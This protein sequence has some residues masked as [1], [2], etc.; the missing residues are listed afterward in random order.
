[1][2]SSDDTGSVPISRPEIL[3][4]DSDFSSSTGTGPLASP[5]QNEELLIG[6]KPLSISNLSSWESSSSTN[7][8]PTTSDSCC[9]LPIARAKKTEFYHNRDEIND[10][11]CRYT[12]QIPTTRESKHGE[13]TS[14]TSH[15]KLPPNV[16]NFPNVHCATA[17]TTLFSE[18]MDMKYAEMTHRQLTL[19]LNQLQ[20]HCSVSKLDPAST[21]AMNKVLNDSHLRRPQAA[22]AKTSRCVKFDYSN[23]HSSKADCSSPC[24]SKLA[25]ILKIKDEMLQEK[26]TTIV[27]LRL[28]ISSLQ[29]QAQETEAVLHQV[30]CFC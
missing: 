28:Q 9:T 30:N 14:M 3:S 24:Y 16:N 25:Q 20:D 19:S 7:D 26:E 5:K 18:D 4:L 21:Y 1:M 29:H 8:N 17:M 27:R 10:I 13:Q 15:H 2:Y 12:K 23:L 6:K 11:I 22:D